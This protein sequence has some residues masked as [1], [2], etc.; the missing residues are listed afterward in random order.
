MPDFDVDFCMARRDEVIDYVADK[1]GVTSVG[2]IATFQNLKARS[3][4]KDVARAM[5]IPAPEA[6]RI[7]SLVPEKG[8][9]KMC[10]IDEA[11]NVEPKLKA[12]V[13]SDPQVR[14]LI[15]QSKKLEGL[16]RHAGLHAAGV[17]DEFAAEIL[18]SL[19]R[20]IENN[21]IEG[22]LLAESAEGTSR[23]S[24]MKAGIVQA[25]LPGVDFGL[26]NRR[27]IILDTDDCGAAPGQ[28]EREISHAAVEIENPFRSL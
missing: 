9:G 6:Q 26:G 5:A 28:G 19:A 24:R 23:R 22:C 27:R 12:Q 1:Y 13:E 8:Q 11:L 2:Q 18:C 25:V 16:T 20:R 10:T 3:V 14:E 15:E 21:E 4:I 7:A 17:V